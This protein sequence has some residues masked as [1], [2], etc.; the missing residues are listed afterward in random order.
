VISAV[1]VAAFAFVGINERGLKIFFWQIDD[2]L[3]N[4]RHVS[5]ALLYKWI[6]VEIGIGIWLSWIGAILALISTA[7]IFPDLINSGSIDL[8]VSKP[9][10]RL[11]LFVLQYLAGL[12]FVTLQVAIFSL[13]GFLV[14]GLRGGVWEPGLF[15]AVPLVVCFFSYLF[16][17]CVLLGL[18]TRSTLASLLLTLLFWLVVSAVGTAERTL[19]MFQTAQR[20]GVSLMQ[21]DVPSE[22]PKQPAHRGAEQ[23]SRSAPRAEAGRPGSGD[24]E[25]DS[26][27]LAVAHRILYGVKTV[28]PKTGDTVDLLERTL[29]S[30]AELPQPSGQRSQ[31]QTQLGREVAET[32]RSRSV[33]WVVGTSLAFELG[34]LAWAAF[35]FC[36]RD[37]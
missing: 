36:R 4:T 17:V 27:G 1:V 35:L 16:S 11:Q 31:R 33:M 3:L 14:I 22:T 10:G 13:A 37:F 21:V 30:L 7:G 24:L 12:L 26:N 9:I 34:V 28:L 6:F 32:L 5:P 20:Q 19:L 8:L 23:A 18:A 25:E 2:D 15:M 29:I